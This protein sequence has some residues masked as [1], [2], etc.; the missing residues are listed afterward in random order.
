MTANDK[1][2]SSAA[3]TVL[4]Y[5]AASKHRLS[6]YAP[7]PEG[8]NWDRQPDPFRTY[9][10]APRV[11]LPQ[12]VT[13][14]TTRYSDLT[15][16]GTVA[17]A[18][19]TKD[20]IGTLL[21]LSLGV[22]AWKTQGP[23]S[24]AV[25]CNPSSGNLHPTEAYVIAGGLPDLADGLYH[26][27]SADHLLEQRCAGSV[28][29][30]GLWIG[31]ST[32]LWREAW[33]YGLRSL[34]YCALDVGHALGAVT[35][36]A[37]SLGWSVRIV[38]SCG[39]DELGKL[40]GT[41]QPQTIADA[42][43]ESPELLL[44]IQPGSR[45]EPPQI[46]DPVWHGTASR[47][48]PHPPRHWPGLLDAQLATRADTRSQA[49][50]AQDLTERPQPVARRRSEAQAAPLIRNRRSA[51]RFTSKTLVPAQ[52]LFEL[53]SAALPT[54]SP[55]WDLWDHAPRCH[56]MVFVHRVADLAEGLY[57]LPRSA[58]GAAGLQSALDPSFAWDRVDH[59]PGPLPLYK[60]RE[61][62]FRPV[63]RRLSCHQAIAAEGA[64][65]FAMLAEFEPVVTQ[66]PWRYRQLHWEAGL[67]GQALYL[68]AEHEGL[69]GSGIGCFLD[70]EMHG[71]LGLTSPRFQVLYHF[72]A[73][74][75]VEASHNKTPPP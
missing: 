1:I 23:D 9:H 34:R 18:P 6:A 2:I 14:P 56:L 64:V 25:R 71:L 3:Q 36:A 49:S 65:T 12:P 15:G 66:T 16:P 42:E 52:S 54:H 48:D 59:A 8:L 35:Y 29:P 27:S 39:H 40:L 43:P 72:A 75:A 51:R 69:R 38:E 17:P 61:D 58:A 20:S 44:Q 57:A 11:P 67:I 10:G 31:L 68:A 45:A 47:C 74:Y 62:R 41:D 21:A 37:A 73:G 5:H 7:G 24:W 63:V 13:E 19:F 70:D 55:P 30:D 22:S 46:T 26:Y 4:S 28:S 32:I 53:L 33:K 60:L 50:S